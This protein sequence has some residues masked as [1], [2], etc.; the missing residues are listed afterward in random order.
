M[1]YA[2]LNTRMPTFAPG[3]SVRICLARASPSAAF[4]ATLRKKCASPASAS[5]VAAG[6]KTMVPVG[7][8]TGRMLC[9]TLE[10]SGPT[11]AEGFAWMSALMFESPVALWSPSL[12]SCEMMQAFLPLTPPAA[13]MSDRAAPTPATAGGARNESEPVRGRNEPR[14]KTDDESSP[15]PQAAAAGRTAPL[16]DDAESAGAGEPEAQPATVSAMATVAA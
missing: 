8:V 11:M 1:P 5:S 7:W 10:D 2:S 9:V 12:E 16:P 13:L 6:E 4:G 3:T 14:A 15:E